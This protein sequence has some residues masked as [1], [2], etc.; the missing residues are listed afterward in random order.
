MIDWSEEVSD[1]MSSRQQEEF[2]AALHS[3]ACAELVEQQIKAGL[4]RILAC[5]FS[6]EI[7]PAPTEQPRLLMQGVMG[8]L[9]WFEDQPPARVRQRRLQR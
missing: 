7:P 1:L 9:S 3:K 4:D 6:F 2:D 5:D 8:L